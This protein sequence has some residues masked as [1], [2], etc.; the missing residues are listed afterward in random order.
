MEIEDEMVTTEHENSPNVKIQIKNKTTDWLNWQRD[1]NQ[2]GLLEPVPLVNWAIAYDTDVYENKI[3]DLVKGLKLNAAALGIEMKEPKIY[4]WGDLEKILNDPSRKNQVKFQIVLSVAYGRS[5]TKYN[6]IKQVLNEKHGIPSQN[7]RIRSIERNRDSVIKNILAQMNSKAFRNPDKNDFTTGASWSIDESQTAI[8]E[9]T[10]IVGIDVWHGFSGKSKS[11]AGIVAS[12]DG[13]MHYLAEPLAL[14]RISQEIITDLK[15]IIGKWI[16]AFKNV[17]GRFPENVIILRDGV[18]NS[19]MAE[20][21]RTEFNFEFGDL[22]IPDSE[23]PKLVV[24]VQTK[25]LEEEFC[26]RP[27]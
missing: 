24:I 9:N 21:I 13:G 25:G 6:R 12:F 18:G 4:K 15:P 20:L 2:N 17:K 8:P 1:L 14:N 16:M 23:K 26:G 19:Q 11:I 10:M 5:K 3:T 27:G 7:M 22:K